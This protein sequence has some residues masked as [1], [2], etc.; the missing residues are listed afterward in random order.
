[1][2]VS[3]LAATHL[4]GFGDLDVLHK[5]ESLLFPLYVLL[6]EMR[7]ERFLDEGKLPA[8]LGTGPKSS[9]QTT[10]TIPRALTVR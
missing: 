1:M 8:S 6:I 5:L 2:A 4:G 3:H 10:T 7:E 9:L